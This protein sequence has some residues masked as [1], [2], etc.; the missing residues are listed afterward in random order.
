MRKILRPLLFLSLLLPIHPAAAQ[1]CDPRTDCRNQFHFAIK[2]SIYPYSED[3]AKEGALPIGTVTLSGPNGPWTVIAT[4]CVQESQNNL[5]TS[6]DFNLRMLAYLQIGSTT[7]APRGEYQVQFLIDGVPRGWFVRT[8]KGMLPQGDHFGS[9]ATNVPAGT[10]RFEVQARLMASGTMTFTEQFITS[11]GAPVSFPYFSDTAS[12]AMTID[13]T[14]RRVTNEVAFTNTVAVDL[15]PIAYLEWDSG[16]PNDKVTVKFMLDGAE[17]PHNSDVAV[18]PFFRDGIH[19]FDHLA[20]VPAGTH[21]ISLWAK[22]NVARAASV[23]FRTMALASYP[24][25]SAHPSNPILRDAF[26]TGTV[27][28]NPSIPSAEQPSFSSG[29]KCGYWTKILEF[30][31]P[32]VSGTFNWTGE[33]YVALLGNRTGDWT[34]T[35]AAIAIEA[36]SL[37]PTPFSS[38]MHFVAISPPNNLGQIYFYADSMFWGDGYGQ[39]VKLWMRKVSGCGYTNGTFDVGRRYLSLKLVPTDGLSCYDN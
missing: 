27:T 22:N 4:G 2:N 39:K 35:R 19:I 5:F 11:M 9:I 17:P 3:T 38:D 12:A 25:A 14:W 23:S 21:S 36:I 26:A 30:D 10:H 7:V 37:S 33:G 29:G 32:P 8:Y 18:P 13:G 6:T 1:Y 31:M 20:N 28:I 16:M 34:T 15:Y 24:A